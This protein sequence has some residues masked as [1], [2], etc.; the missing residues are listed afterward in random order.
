LLFVYSTSIPIGIS[1]ELGFEYPLSKDNKL[2]FL[3]NLQCLSASFSPEK[4]TVTKYIVNGKDMVSA[5]SV[6]EKSTV[7]KDSYVLDPSV[8]QDP[9]KPYTDSRVPFPFSS[10]GLNLGIKYKIR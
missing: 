1:A 9:S 2:S 3:F 5:L 4:G 8:K 6:S 10:I 7:F